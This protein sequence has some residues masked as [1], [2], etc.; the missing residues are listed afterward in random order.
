MMTLTEHARG[1]ILAVKAQPGARRNSVVG[2][3]SGALRVAVTAAPERGRANEAIV[4][5]LSG[6]LGVRPSRI[7]L[8]NGETSREK[9]FL[10]EEMTP[11]DL[12]VRLDALLGLDI[13]PK[14]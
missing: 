5:V 11:A 8:L 3:R 13:H 9:R 1:T 6:A 14:S 2:E 12:L 10:I 4:G 7:R